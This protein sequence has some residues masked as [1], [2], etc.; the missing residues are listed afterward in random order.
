MNICLMKSLDR[1]VG[2]LLARVLPAPASVPVPASPASFLLIRPGGMG[3]AV[4][5]A[6]AVLALRKAFPLAAIDILAEKRNAAV[7]SLLEGVRRVIRYDVPAEFLSLFRGNYDLVI[8]TEQWHY[9]SA[10]VARLINGRFRA[11]FGTNSRSR[12][13]NQVVG[14]PHE[15]YEADSFF[16]LLEPFKV[17]A[18]V[19]GT[20]PWLVV[21]FDAAA[22]GASLLTL[23]EGKRF[24]VIFPGASIPERQWGSERF[25]E[26]AQYIRNMG[27]GV[28]VVGGRQDRATGDRICANGVGINLAGKTTLAE[29]AAIIDRSALLISGDSG[30]LHIG[31]ALGKPTV[32]LFG[33]GIAA[34]W[35]PRGEGHIVL[36]RNLSCSPCTKF[37]T[38]PPC[39][40]S[41]RCMTEITASDVVA[42][43]ERLLS[44]ESRH[45]PK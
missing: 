37:G 8:D 40:H 12:L 44:P 26:V 4:H 22:Q 25:R 39:P 45:S 28:V 3:D 5:L 24:M 32:S 36:N 20:P 43:V 15:D 23:L 42:A 1:I 14:Y 31:V 18:G 2:T 6:P 17:T 21:P 9:L 11:G 41:V 29:T 30:I 27:M 19:R 35:A 16:R 7:F 13:F 10:V 34:K 33:P 38:T